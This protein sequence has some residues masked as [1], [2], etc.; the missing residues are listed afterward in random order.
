MSEGSVSTQVTCAWWGDGVAEGGA[1]FVCTC[2]VVEGN[3]SV[4]VS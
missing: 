4:T 1:T 3:G 2:V